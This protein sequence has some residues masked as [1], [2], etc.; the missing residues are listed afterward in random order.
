MLKEKTDDV[1]VVNTNQG[2]ARAAEAAPPTGRSLWKTWRENLLL[3]CLTGVY[4]ELCL[5][6]CVFRSPGRYAGYLVLF[7][8]LGG[9]LCTLLASSLPKILRQ[10]VGVLLVAA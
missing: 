4:A 8:L 1:S 5:H 2:S 9:A 10:I 7:G 3:F 6:L